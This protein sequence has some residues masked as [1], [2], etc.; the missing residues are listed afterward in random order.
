MKKILKFVST[1]AVWIFLAL[2]FKAILS[3][4]GLST[5]G[6]SV[7]LALLVFIFCG[8]AVLDKI[9]NR[10]KNKTKIS[11]SSILKIVLPL[12][13]M[14]AGL[15]IGETIIGFSLIIIAFLLSLIPNA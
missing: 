4:S 6:T 15:I 8:L 11:L 12:G 1:L 14:M 10:I 9:K 3:L 13:F 5:E 2:V 7:G